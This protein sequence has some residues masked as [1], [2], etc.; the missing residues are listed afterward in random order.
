MVQVPLMLEESYRPKGWLGMIL[1]V[2]L[3][4][5]FYGTTLASKGA[6]EGKMEELCRELGDRGTHRAAQA[7][8]SSITVVLSHETTSLSSAAALLDDDATIK[9]DFVD[10]LLER[11]NRI[12]A[13]SVSRKDRKELSKRTDALLD[14][15]DNDELPAWLASVWTEEQAA[16]MVGASEALVV[17]ENATG[18]S[19]RDMASAVVS[20]L[21][22]ME[23]VV[24]SHVDKAEALLASMQSGESGEVVA[25]LEHGL[26][27]LEKLALSST[28]KARRAID[29][30][31]ERLEHAIE[32]LDD[33]D[34]AMEQLASCEVSELTVLAEQLKAASKL[35]E[36][37]G[38][39][40][41]STVTMVLET[42]GRCC[43]PVLGASRQLTSTDA[44]A[45]MRGLEVLRSL[46]RAVLTDAAAA[47]VSV[48]S[49]AVEIGLD[50]SRDCGERQAACMSVFVLGFRN[51]DAT[52]E[53]VGKFFAEGFTAIV[54]P[55]FSN[56]L[57][58]REGV[59]VWAA[60]WCATFSL[61]SPHKVC[62]V[63]LSRLDFLLF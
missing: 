13:I 60:W 5:G 59:A 62:G 9:V 48:A 53:L 33:E 23:E 27:M 21:A 28:R 42:L 40:C 36:E 25:V 52:T 4:Y 46:P 49:I 8:E 31:C 51:G 12:I 55:A 39:R 54:G 14:D 38:K 7:A 44:G 2:R 19:S 26:T 56:E 35:D 47:E 18:M 63:F 30:L 24:A 3:W 20:V 11:T 16:A 1:G 61:L 43:D 10:G 6:F 22:A 29:D 15:L 45:R 34:G 57:S 58:G 17:A 50:R 32:S 37:A 41:V